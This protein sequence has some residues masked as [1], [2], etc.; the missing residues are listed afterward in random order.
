MEHA[1]EEGGA[2]MKGR[3]ERR[4]ADMRAVRELT[5]R[6]ACLMAAVL[7]M[8][9]L[10][11]ASAV[12]EGTRELML[13]AALPKSL[14]A[15][16]ETPV[17]TRDPAIFIRLA[18]VDDDV[19]PEVIIKLMALTPA[20]PAKLTGNGP[21]VLVYHTHD[22]EAYRPTP[23][24]SYKPSGDFRTEE[25]EMSVMAVGEE[26]CRILREEYGIEAVHAAE[27]HEQPLITTAYS[28][29]LETMLYYKE[30]YPTLEM[31]ID[32]HRDGVADTGWEDDF[33]LVDGI[34]CARMMF[35]VGTGKS[36]K[37]SQSDPEP[38]AGAVETPD[39]ESNYSL[40][41]SLTETLLTYN[42]RF[43]RSV[44]VKSGTYNQ[45]VSSECLL[46]EVGHNGNTLEQ[47]K[48]SM[49]YLAKAIAEVTGAL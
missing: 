46:V 43:M 15:P 48:N 45:Q 2:G 41:I 39:F 28:R 24:A 40:A 1:A 13:A 22:T 20:E 18:D 4:R 17:P 37:S 35:V 49:I 11:F 8:L 36:G 5:E 38:S 19:S 42:E 27:R 21:K 32:L 14:E 10:L 3:A 9:F 44:R 23:E 12:P 31:F 47:A 25:A 7:I 26:L 33:V 6:A 29:S 34:E 30:L 16:V